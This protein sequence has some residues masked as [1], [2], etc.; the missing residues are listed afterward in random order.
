MR[1]SRMNRRKFLKNAGKSLVG[2][3]LLNG[4]MT[5][6]LDS[7]TRG[8][9]GR[10]LAAEA[11]IVPRKWV[12]MRFDFAPPRW[13][14]DLFLQNHANDRALFTA[15]A[16][17]CL[18]ST[19]YTKSGNVATGAIYET[20]AFTFNAG[21]TTRTVYAPY[22]WNYHVPAVGGG[23][24]PMKDL[25]NNFLHIRGFDTG[26]PGHPG[27]RALH[28]TPLGASQSLSALSADY[29][30]SPIAAAVFNVTDYGFRSMASKSPFNLAGA[31]LIE[32]LTAP[33]APK[34]T[35]TNVRARE[36]D[37]ASYLEVARQALKAQAKARH[38]DS[39]AVYD[40]IDGARE[41]VLSSIGELS[42]QWQ[43]LLRKYNDLIQRAL[44][45]AYV[46]EH[47]IPGLTDAPIGI[48]GARGNDY[49]LN[50]EK[51]FN[52]DLRTLFSASTTIAN[53][54]A[55]FAIT[56]FILLNNFSDSITVG[57][58]G[59]EN[60]SAKLS[61]SGAM[62]MVIPSFDEHFTGGMVSLLLNSMHARAHSACLLELIDR[63]KAVG[64]W[65]KTVINCGAEFNRQPATDG[66]GSDHAFRGASLAVYSGIVDGPH[67]LGDIAQNSNP[68]AAEGTWGDGVVQT[69]L[70]NEK[71]TLNLG[72]MSATV[73]QLLGVKSPVTASETLLY[74]SGGKIIPR[75]NPGKIV[76]V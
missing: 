30:K 27:A 37:V 52:S 32:A 58:N 28:Y 67:I 20:K 61:A 21:G 26:N 57:I 8:S 9:I 12:D 69:W 3:G 5:I 49:K 63:V 43:P 55:S 73:A 70:T 2:A 10:A 22:L 41:L 25:L 6:L 15:A 16:R 14:Y 7:I 45:A 62:Q 34:Q 44:M 75:L 72:N 51:V 33:F 68:T 19:R 42:S 13:V 39:A 54:A 38:Q 60:I 47:Y 36:R 76:G 48:S 29:S 56:E 23:T 46:P 71:S 65:D 35:P 74:V 1:A 53:M 18:V 11:G 40:A 31:N 4:P 64:L 50:D 59:F 66:S 17:N 24:R